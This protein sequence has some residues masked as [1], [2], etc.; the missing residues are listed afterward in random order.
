MSDIFQT[1][2]FNKVSLG[3]FGFDVLGIGIAN[4][5]EYRVLNAL[6]ASQVTVINKADGQTTTLT[7]PGGFQLFGQ[8]ESVNVISG[9]VI[10]YIG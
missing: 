1:G 5:K 7:L 9:S 4:T 10:A 3:D 6:E 8:F 2:N